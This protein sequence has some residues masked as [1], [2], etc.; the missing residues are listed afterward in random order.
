[1][2]DVFSYMG[3]GTKLYGRSDEYDGSYVATVWIVIIWLPVIP[4]RSYRV[5]PVGGSD[6]D[7]KP[8]LGVSYT[9]QYRM[10]KVKMN[11]KQVY[12]TYLAV[13]PAA[14]IFL[15][16]CFVVETIWKSCK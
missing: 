7:Y 9:K 10:I 4:L 13:Y 2:I 15:L 12:R 5:R 6:F 8:I 1:M 16:I 11:W 3:C 14:I